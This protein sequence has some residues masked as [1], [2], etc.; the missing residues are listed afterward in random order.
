MTSSQLI[1]QLKGNIMLFRLAL[2]NIARQKRRTALTL[3]VLA[4]GFMALAMAGGFMSQTFSG[5]SEGSIR[6]GIGHIQILHPQALEQ[7]EG[8]SLEFALPD[9]ESLSRQLMQE[10]EIKE[11]LPRIQFMGLLSNGNR[12]VAVLGTGVDPIKEPKFMASLDQLKEGSRIP[13]GIGSRWLSKE[14]REAIIGIGLAKSLGA[15]IGE[16][17]TLLVTTRDG[18][19]NALDVEIVGFQ[20]L[21]FKELNDRFLTISLGTASELLSAGKAIS[22]LS[23]ILK[24][25]NNVESMT[26]Q[27]QKTLG[28][29]FKV[30]PWYELASFYR[31]VKLLYFAIFGFMGIVLGLVILLATVNTLLMSVMERVREFGTLRALGLQPNQLLVLLQ[32]EGSLIGALG[33]IL[34]H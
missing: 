16:N 19:L 28:K 15:K 14:G 25:P 30:M 24:N 11:V 5:L 31:Q 8:Q 29:Q 7:D 12:S 33:C 27:L 2:R 20:D 26:K 32:W 18:A 17:L 21:G 13:E 1:L 34:V 4:A 3:S 23:I 22:R 6:G 9:A 10:Q